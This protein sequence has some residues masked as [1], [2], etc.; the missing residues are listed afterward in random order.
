MAL[1]LL[2][3]L[4][5]R[6]YHPA[7]LVVVAVTAV[8]FVLFSLLRIFSSFS[9]NFSSLWTGCSFGFVRFRLRSESEPNEDG[10]E[11]RSL[12]S[13]AGSSSRVASK[14]PRSLLRLLRNPK[15][16]FV[17]ARQRIR[18]TFGQPTLCVI[19]W[20]PFVDCRS[21]ADPGTLAGGRGTAR[22]LQARRTETGGGVLGRGSQPPPHL[23]RGA[24]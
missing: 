1:F 14:S 23:L 10:R 13:T 12:R 16:S 3:E 20:N 21:V 5:I 24:L 15:Q 11:E 6:R 4:Q 8:E 7:L 9:E 2:A 17:K 19:A 18:K 22:Q